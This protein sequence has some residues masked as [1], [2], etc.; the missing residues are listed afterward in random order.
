ML[1]LLIL[2]FYDANS[3]VVASALNHLG[4]CN[5][6]T[7]VRTDP[8]ITSIATNDIYIDF[9]YRVIVDENNLTLNMRGAFAINDGGYHHWVHTIA[10]TNEAQAAIIR[11]KRW[12]GTT[13]SIKK[14]G[15][16][17]VLWYHKNTCSHSSYSIIVAHGIHHRH[18]VQGK[19]NYANLNVVVP[20]CIDA[21]F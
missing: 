5:D 12:A 21:A 4:A 13:E 19:C 14:Q 20:S 18:R 17:E 1:L 3:D 15:L 11:E 16:G 7:L 6:K 10:G 9:M 2:F 8:F